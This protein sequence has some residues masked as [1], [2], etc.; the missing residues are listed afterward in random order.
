MNTIAENLRAACEEV[1]CAERNHCR[2]LNDEALEQRQMRLPEAELVSRVRSK[3]LC[4]DT[5]MHAQGKL[6]EPDMVSDSFKTECEFKYFCGESQLHTNS[7]LDWHWLT[8]HPDPEQ[9]KPLKAKRDFS[10]LW[11]AFFPRARPEFSIPKTGIADKKA[12]WI[13]QSCISYTATCAEDIAPFVSFATIERPTSKN[14]KQLQPRTHFRNKPIMKGILV[15]K[16]E[17]EFV[18][19]CD[20][21]GA[22]FEDPIWCALYEPI[23]SRNI[24]ELRDQSYQTFELNGRPTVDVRKKKSNKPPAA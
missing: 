4:L 16:Y 14:G 18:I 6:S 12:S 8:N 11:I 10:K 20:V 24:E 21:I 17:V 1:I 7:L 2:N 5:F 13:A 15:C 22:P 23:H 9:L 3:I 19:R